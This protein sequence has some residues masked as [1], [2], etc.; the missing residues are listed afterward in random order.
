MTPT[1]LTRPPRHR[2]C[3]AANAARRGPLRFIVPSKSAQADLEPPHAAPLTGSG[4]VAS[5]VGA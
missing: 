5:G 4:E 1:S 3:R 2:L